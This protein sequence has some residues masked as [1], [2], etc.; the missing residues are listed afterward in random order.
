LAAAA[1][2]VFIW[3]VHNNQELVDAGVWTHAI[4]VF[5]FALLLVSVTNRAANGS[6][7]AY[8]RLRI[9]SIVIPVVSVVLVALP[10]LLPTWMKV[11][12]A[13]YALVLLTVAVL[14]NLH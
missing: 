11:E 1:T 9:I 14:A 12:Q 10:G 13:V 4:I 2:V 7:V 5:G 3:I 8:Q 6:R